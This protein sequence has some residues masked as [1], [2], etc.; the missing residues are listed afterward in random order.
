MPYNIPY[1]RVTTIV[2]LPEKI[3]HTKIELL[4]EI[5]SIL[6]KNNSIPRKSLA[7]SRDI[8]FSRE[9]SIFLSNYVHRPSEEKS[10]VSKNHTV[11]C[12]K[13]IEFFHKNIIPYKVQNLV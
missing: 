4:Y 2:S 7:Y 1:K 3:E 13:K 10:G 6:P 9:I 11:V 8:Y 5:R 12:H